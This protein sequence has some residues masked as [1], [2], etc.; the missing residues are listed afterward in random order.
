VDQW[1]PYEGLLASGFSAQ[2]AELLADGFSAQ[3]AE[4]LASG[5]S[6]QGAEQLVSGSTPQGQAAVGNDSL[7]PEVC[8]LFAWAAREMKERVSQLTGGK[9]NL[10]W[11]GTFHHIGYR[12]LRQYAPVLGYKQNFT[13]LQYPLALFVSNTRASVLLN[14]FSIRS[15][16]V[17]FIIYLL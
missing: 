16:S 15:S 7:D 10:P 3:G 8:A 4:L 5:S 6:A 11:S 14:N 9:G 2:G 13:I 1:A 17:G 12:I